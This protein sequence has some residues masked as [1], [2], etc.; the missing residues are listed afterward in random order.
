MKKRQ[1]DR[2]IFL[3]GHRERFYLPEFKVFEATMR[4]HGIEVVV[5]DECEM[6]MNGDEL[7]VR[8]QPEA[9]RW[10]IN[11]PIMTE[12]LPLIEA[13]AVKYKS[14]EMQCLIPPKPFLGSKVVCA[15]LR[16]D[17]ANAAL[18]AILR[19]QIDHT[20][21]TVIRH[22]LPPTYMVT[23]DTVINTGDPR[24]VLKEVIS[25]GAKGVFFSDD[26]GYT[27]AMVAAKKSRGRFILQEEVQT[28]Q[29]SFRYY[30][31]A[32]RALTVADMYTRIVVYFVAGRP[33]EAVVTASQSKCVHGGKGAVNMGVVIG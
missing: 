19:S 20:A 1:S 24:Y 8:G 25:S 3:Y 31:A 32:N 12:N 17:G 21:L 7:L 26:P 16:N 29:R 2:L 9:S 23:R 11:F 15:L 10:F 18:E 30:G 22:Y 6:Q 4:T 14:G 28:K 33:A 27:A 13:L 5:V